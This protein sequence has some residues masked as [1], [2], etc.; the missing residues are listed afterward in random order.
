[1]AVGKSSFFPMILSNNSII[2]QLKISIP[3][4]EENYGEN[5]TISLNV[6]FDFED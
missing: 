5:A 4:L 1:M 2:D 3:E 6:D